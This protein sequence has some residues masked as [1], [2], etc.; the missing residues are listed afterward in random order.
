[1]GILKLEVTQISNIF[2]WNKNRNLN[3][4]RTCFNFPNHLR[5]TTR[6]EVDPCLLNYGSSYFSV[7]RE[8]KAEIAMR[9]CMQN[10]SP[11]SRQ[12]SILLISTEPKC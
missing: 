1:M 8:K 9:G 11:M 4:I 7:G 10:G 6:Y 12:L 3:S 2:F 5:L